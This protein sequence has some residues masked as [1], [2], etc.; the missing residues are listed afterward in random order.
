MSGQVGW[1]QVGWGQVSWG[2]VE[3]GLA[4][5]DGA[6]GLGLAGLELVGVA[7]PAEQGGFGADQVVEG[8]Q[9]GGVA[10]GLE[11]GGA[12]EPAGAGV[13]E[14]DVPPGPTG[15]LL[16]NLLLGGE[17]GD[18]EG[19][20]PLDRRQSEPVE[21]GGELLVDPPGPLQRQRA[22]LGGDAAGLPRRH[23]QRLDPGP[24]PGQ[25]VAQVEG[26]G[27][28]RHRGLGGD[29][30]RRPQLLGGERRH[31][32][33][34]VPTEGGVTVR[35]PGKPGVTPRR[36][37]RLRSGRVAHAPLVGQRSASPAAPPG[38]AARPRQ[39]QRADRRRRGPRPRPP[40]PCSLPPWT[41]STRDHRQSRRPG[42]RCPQRDRM[43]LR[44]RRPARAPRPP[45]TRV[46]TRWVAWVVPGVPSGR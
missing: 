39:R 36:R 2:Q 24:E 10:G 38:P 8:G 17:P 5:G 43:F 13:A 27:H 29:P 44:R 35:Q 31:P 40:S 4:G 46:T 21:A 7:Q 12:R 9:V 14:G 11:P 32:R 3:V 42:N 22:G 6:E 26:V 19:D 18:S 30:Q 41:H 45:G 15:P 25:S 20:E 23:R 33:R 16:H 1:G 28:Q 34:P 37:T